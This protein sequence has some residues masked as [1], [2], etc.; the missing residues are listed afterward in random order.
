[1]KPL[2]NACS[3]IDKLRSFR[4]WRIKV[5]RARFQVVC[6]TLVVVSGNFFRA[7]AGAH[8]AVPSVLQSVFP[9]K[10]SLVRMLVQQMTSC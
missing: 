7:N 3:V 8:R 1:M 10:L 6:V 4:E 9:G 5:R 2:E